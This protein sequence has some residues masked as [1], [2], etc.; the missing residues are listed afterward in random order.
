M[1]TSATKLLSAL[2]LAVLGVAL[3]AG[4]IY[5]AE[6]DDAPGAAL[7]GFLLMIALVTG[8]VK[9]VRERNGSHANRNE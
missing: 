6:I 5:V 8:A 2:G 9:I 7:I 4:S 1:T 3:A